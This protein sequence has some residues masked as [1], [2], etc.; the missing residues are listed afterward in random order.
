[1]QDEQ[2]DGVENEPAPPHEEQIIVFVSVLEYLPDPEHEEQVVV[3]ATVP[4]P[5]QVSH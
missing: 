1:M 5:W 2:A 4:F 3:D